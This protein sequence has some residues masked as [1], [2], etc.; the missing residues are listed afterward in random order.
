MNSNLPR[1]SVTL[2]GT[3]PHELY[4]RVCDEL[5]SKGVI[6]SSMC[7]EE[8]AQSVVLITL[9]SC[10]SKEEL[11]A[12]VRHIVDDDQIDDLDVHTEEAHAEK[13]I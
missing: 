9:H 6:Y 4:L 8:T 5:K 2:R 12:A 11:T 13:C 7:T 1:A 10:S 3:F